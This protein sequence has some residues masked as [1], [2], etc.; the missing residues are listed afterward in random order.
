MPFSFLGGIFSGGV[1]E[2][3]SGEVAYCDSTL[4]FYIDRG[5]LR[6]RGIRLLLYFVK[7]SV[8]LFANV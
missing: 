3:R 1:S 5:L 7:P 8:T 4:I 6:K 2:F